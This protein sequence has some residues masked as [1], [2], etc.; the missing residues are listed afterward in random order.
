MF[1]QSVLREKYLETLQDEF[2]SVVDPVGNCAPYK[3]LDSSCP[4]PKEALSTLCSSSKDRY[5]YQ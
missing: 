4:E 2:Y 3:Q 1:F 5:G